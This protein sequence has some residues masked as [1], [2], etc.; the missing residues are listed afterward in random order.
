MFCAYTYTHKAGAEA[1][2]MAPWVKCLPCKCED[3]TWTSQNP[4]KTGAIVGAS[5]IPGLPK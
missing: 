1:G 2:A 3:L 5:I 4:S